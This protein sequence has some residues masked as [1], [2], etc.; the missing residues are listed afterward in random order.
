MAEK[1][2]LLRNC[3]NSIFKNI[4]FEVFLVDNASTD[5]TQS[6]IVKREFPKGKM[7][8]NRKNL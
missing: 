8:C 3:L 4:K 1:K 7:L 5:D 6:I 2:E